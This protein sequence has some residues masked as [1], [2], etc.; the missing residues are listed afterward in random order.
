M[1]PFT[2]I[3]GATAIY[4]GI[5]SATEA[6]EDVIQT[7]ERVGN[8][9]SKVAQV[10]QLTSMPFKKKL[11]QSQADFE[12]QATDRYAAKAKAQELQLAAKNLFVSTYGKQ[13][14][15]N[16]QREVIEM[17]KQAAREAAAEEKR[18]EEAR[19]DLIIVSTIVLSLICAMAV[20]G[21]I[22]LFTVK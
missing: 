15:E 6:G 19:Q 12:K 8:L 1:D 11:F 3:A 10:V 16:I 7:A 22:L 14:W 5:K 13:A 20:I 18:M 21:V 4:N 9:F 2:L 17:R